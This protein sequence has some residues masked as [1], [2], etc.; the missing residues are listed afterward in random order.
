[1]QLILYKTNLSP[2]LSLYSFKNLQT[3]FPFSVSTLIRYIP[4]FKFETGIDISPLTFGFKFNIVFPEILTTV[5]VCIFS[6]DFT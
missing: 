2:L 6:S 1:M 5:I 3:L 4:L